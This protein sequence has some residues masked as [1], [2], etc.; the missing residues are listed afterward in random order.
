MRRWAVDREL[1]KR[2]EEEATL[3]GYVREAEAAR[4]KRDEHEQA[5]QDAEVGRG[6]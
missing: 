6:S 2:I 1:M 5:A 4:A 3:H